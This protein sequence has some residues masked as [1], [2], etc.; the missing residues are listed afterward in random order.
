MRD[1]K[2]ISPLH[3]VIDIE[4]S[5][6]IALYFFSIFKISLF[7]ISSFVPPKKTLDE[8]NLEWKN[9]RFVVTYSRPDTIMLSQRPQAKLLTYSYPY[10]NFVF[11]LT[12]FS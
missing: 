10:S 3:V 12:N 4:L 7:G 1:V 11:S 6:I 5:N 9:K 2:K 8:L